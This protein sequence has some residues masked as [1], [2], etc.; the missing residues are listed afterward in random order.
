MQRH[1]ELDRTLRRRASVIPRAFLLSILAFGTAWA[2]EN[3]VNDRPNAGNAAVDDG[4]A[5]ELPNAPTEGQFTD[6]RASLAYAYGLDRARGLLRRFEYFKAL[7]IELDTEMAKQGFI[8]AFAEAAER[9]G[10]ARLTAEQIRT[11]IYAFDREIEAAEQRRARDESSVNQENAN[12][13]LAENATKPG[14]VTL[15][16]GLQ[17]RVLH[18]GV[19]T[20]AGHSSK[21]ILHFRGRLT[22]GR[23]FAS[24]YDE[25]RQPGEFRV[26]NVL[27]GWME[28]LQLMRVG[29]RWELTIP[30]HLAFGSST[31]GLV[32]ANAV[33]IYE[34][35]VLE[36]IDSGS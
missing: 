29:D 11:L 18:T 9:D 14:V 5:S 23:V 7:G 27:A 32:P 31:H 34:L 35:E 36:V 3:D 26:S 28:A 33:V 8:D 12:R 10:A 21:V 25:G 4:P 17:Y 24:S 2:G 30:P 1:S 6:D 13:Y 16:S 20:E 19:G 22:D 15:A